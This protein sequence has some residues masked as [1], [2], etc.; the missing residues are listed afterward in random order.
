MRPSV[1][2]DRDLHLHLAVGAA[3]HGGHVVAQ[4]QALGGEPEPVAHRLVVGHL[5]ALGR[6]SL[7]LTAQ[8]LPLDSGAAVCP[9]SPTRDAARSIELR[10]LS[11]DADA[12]RRKCRMCHVVRRL[13]N[14]KAKGDL[15]ELK[16]APTW[17]PRL[18]RSHFR[19]ERTGDGDV[20]AVPRREAGTRGGAST[21]WIGWQ[22]AGDDSGLVARN[23][24]SQPRK[25]LKLMRR[26]TARNGRRGSPRTRRRL[27]IGA[28][29]YAPS[30]GPRN[31]HA[32]SSLTRHETAGGRHPT[33]HRLPRDMRWS[34]PGSNRRPRR[35]KRGALPTELWPQARP[36]L[37]RPQPY[38]KPR[39]SSRRACR[40]G[41]GESSST[42]PSVRPPRRATPT[43]Q[44]PASL[45]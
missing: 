44:R 21:R 19:T 7:G 37:A 38:R 39:S 11:H 43:K 23:I 33:S 10:V 3:Q 8:L 42:T 41:S 35:C 34:Q 17:W 32:A 12:R 40:P 30:S 22:R 27:S 9:V 20:I 28:T 5:R 31:E 25:R 29:T 15:A 26:Y 14:L 6:R 1:E 2:R 13:L 45:V 4:A 16:V 36:I 18:R 24:A